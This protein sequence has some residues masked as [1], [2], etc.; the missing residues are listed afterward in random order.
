[1]SKVPHKGEES[2]RTLALAAGRSDTAAS[3]LEARVCL[4][5]AGV[6]VNVAAVRMLRV[7][8]GKVVRRSGGTVGDQLGE[9]K[10]ESVRAE[11]AA[12]AAAL[13][14]KTSLEPIIP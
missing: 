10:N 7:R 3:A 9:A 13:S 1:M 11:E 14:Y 4:V 5:E 6:M 8:L 12:D 2:M